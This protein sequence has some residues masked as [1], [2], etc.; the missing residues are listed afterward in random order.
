MSA[1]KTSKPTAKAPIY[2]QWWFWLVII[3]VLGGIAIGVSNNN[4]GPKKVGENGD[5]SSSS[6]TEFKVGDIILMDNVEISVTSIVRNYSTGNQ[7]ITPKSGK[8]YVKVN[9]NINNKSNETIPFNA[10]NWNIEDSDGVIDSYSIFAAADDALNSG[11]L[12]KGGKKS[13]SIVF[14]VPAGDANLK[15]HYKPSFLSNKEVIIN[16]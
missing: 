12:A 16:L 1:K 7:Y 5:Q 9:V 2:K 10:L 11:E 4:G 3:L 13:G 14:E 6:Q 8:E 15:L